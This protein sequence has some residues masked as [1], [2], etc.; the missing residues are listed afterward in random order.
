MVE[1]DLNVV[2]AGG[3][4]IIEERGDQCRAIRPC[5]A[6]IGWPACCVTALDTVL[7]VRPDS[8]SWCLSICILSNIPL[9]PLSLS[10]SLSLSLLSSSL[11]VFHSPL[12]LSLC[13]SLFTS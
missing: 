6:L 3:G 7:L 12:S 11:C 2:T 13:V 10:L 8:A 4:L 5:C 1:C 9:S